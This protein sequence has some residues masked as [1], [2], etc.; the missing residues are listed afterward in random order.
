LARRGTNAEGRR[1][2]DLTRIGFGI[3]DEFGNGLDPKRWVDHEDNGD[4]C[5]ARNWRDVADEIE[6]QIS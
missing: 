2:G 4:A 5:D 1:H 6:V 3:G